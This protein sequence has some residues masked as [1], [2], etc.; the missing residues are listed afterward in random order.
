MIG[1]AQVA[2]DEPVALVVD[3]PFDDVV[4]L[5]SVTAERQREETPGAIAGRVL[6]PG[7]GDDPLVLGLNGRVGTGA[8]GNELV[9][10]EREY[11]PARGRVK[12]LAARD[13]GGAQGRRGVVWAG[14]GCLGELCGDA[15]VSAEGAWLGA[16]ERPSR[17]ATPIVD[18]TQRVSGSAANMS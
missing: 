8:P 1:V 14:A 7:K 11:R 9:Q 5:P 18:S 6:L 4:L 2:G 17:S 3:D 15:L 10:L 13:K 16:Y 12:N